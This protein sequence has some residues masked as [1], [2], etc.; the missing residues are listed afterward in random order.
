MITLAVSFCAG[1]GAVA[2][3]GVDRAVARRAH[4]PWPLGT[5]LVN[6]TGSLLLGLV[7]GLGAH[8]GFDHDAVTVL[9][10]GFAGGYTTLSTWALATVLLAEERERRT[11]AAHAVLSVGA[12]L[13]AAAAGLG[14]AQI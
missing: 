3:Y 11:A 10:S 8:H 9:G 2:R 6:V 1:L 4:S 5:F 14:L 12:G 7:V 13:L